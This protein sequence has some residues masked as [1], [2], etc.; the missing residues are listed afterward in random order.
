MTDYIELVLV[1]DEQNDLVLCIAPAWTYFDENEEIQYS[2]DDGKLVNGH[3]IRSA[4]V[5]IDSDEYELI[6]A[7]TFSPFR[8]IVNKV[9]YKKIAWGDKNE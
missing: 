8:K 9:N 5:Q 1:K 2:L 7:Y 6:K 4:T 3:V